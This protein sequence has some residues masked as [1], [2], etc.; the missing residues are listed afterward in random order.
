MLQD[1]RNQSPT[2]IDHINGFAYRYLK[3]HAQPYQ[4]NKLLWE[5]VNA[6]RN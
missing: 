4:T 5:S 2:E 6:L 3:Q 1:V